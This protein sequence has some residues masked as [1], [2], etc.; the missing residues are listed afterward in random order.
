MV[1]RGTYDGV[2]GGTWNVA[3]IVVLPTCPRKRLQ[4]L[5][6]L[7]HHA[8]W[9]SPS[10]DSSSS[11]RTACDGCRG[12]CSR[13][14]KLRSRGHSMAGETEELRWCNGQ[15]EIVFGSC[16]ASTAVSNEKYNAHSHAF[17]SFVDMRHQHFTRKSTH[18]T[19]F[20]SSLQHHRCEQE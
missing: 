6:Q 1:E 12:T 16:R 4:A 15:L 14:E 19:Y 10:E 7:L 9:R 13:R 11:S 18:R 8:K 5:E 3:D 17:S 2:S 20:R